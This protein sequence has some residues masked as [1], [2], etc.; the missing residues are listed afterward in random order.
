MSTKPS[1]VMVVDDLPAN[2]E[3][4]GSLLRAEGYRVLQF[5]AGQLALHAAEREAPD[6]VLLDILMPEMDGIQVCK[7]LR[8]LPH[9]NETPILFVS[10]LDDIQDK[11]DAFRAGGVDYIPKP[12]EKLE[13]LARVRTHLDL[14]AARRDLNQQNQELD[15]LVRERTLALRRVQSLAKIGGWSVDADSRRI[16][17]MDLTWQIPGLANGQPITF[18]DY[19]QVVHADDRKAMKSAWNTFWAFGGR[20]PYEAEYRVVNSHGTHWLFSELEAEFNDTGSIVALRGFLQDIT[21]R[22]LREREIADERQRLRNALEA[23][24]ASTWEWNP[25]TDEA[26][27]DSRWAAQLG[28]QVEELEPATRAQWHERVHPDDIGAACQQLQACVEGTTD[29]YQAEYRIRHRQGHW[30]WWR[31]RARALRHSETGQATLIA[32]IDVDI[33]RQREQEDAIA[34]AARLDMATGLGNRIAF[35]EH[36]GQQL[37]RQQ[38]GEALLVTVVYI[39]LDDF[40]AVNNAYGTDAGDRCINEIATRLRRLVTRDDDLA[41]VGS[42]EFALLLTDVHPSILEPRLLAIRQAISQAISH[43]GLRINLTA[44]LGASQFRPTA[45]VD[46]E[47]L[48]RQADHAMYQAKLSGKNRHNIFDNAADSS[49]REKFRIIEDVAG[50][51]RNG[52]FRLHYQPKIHMPTG[53]LIGFEALIRWQNP[54]RGLLSPAKFI[55]LLEQHPVA[56]DLQDW[57]IGEAMNQLLRWDREGLYTTISINVDSTNLHDPSFPAKLRAALHSRGTVDAERMELEVLETSAMDDMRFVSEQLKQLRDAGFKISLDDFGTGFSSLTFL[58][59]LPAQLIKI[60]QSFVRALLDTADNA[61]IIQSIMALSRSFHRDVLAEGVES[62]LH[63]RLLLELGCQLGQGYAI[64]RPMPADAVHGWLR[65]WRSPPEWQRCRSLDGLMSEG[66]I[67]E[68]DFR[69][70]LVTGSTRRS[71]LWN[72]LSQPRVRQRMADSG[73][74]ERMAALPRESAFSAGDPDQ[75]RSLL[76]GLFEIRQRGNS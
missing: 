47:Q 14:R 64:A 70:R 29:R 16:H 9:L 8:Q 61:M 73:L 39:D 25:V 4:L 26:A 55:P 51:L 18:E 17:W 20:M 36:V 76:D 24:D 67:A 41:R 75:V 10:A 48:L 60:D 50:G 31:T 40:A 54:Q 62:P 21:E 65:S 44:S 35:C 49:Q 33:T 1:T 38:A 13:V 6:L 5:P 11:I 58:K 23:A 22:K 53:T 27:F 72:W 46:A 34:A 42:D 71:T 12:F 56:V 28:Y 15:E 69:S 32:G 68:L 2:L 7:A 59:S 3:L 63:G 43:G 57:V 37:N 30:L 66:L 19:L 45:T 52:E 74:Q